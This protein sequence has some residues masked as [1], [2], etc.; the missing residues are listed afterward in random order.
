MAAP[1]L[2]PGTI[3]G[4]FRLVEELGAGGMGVVYRAHDTTLKRDVA[5]KVLNAQRLTDEKARQRFHSEALIL[6]RLSHPNVEYVH[7]FRSEEGIDFLVLEYVPGTTLNE[8]IKRGALPEQEV[9]GLGIQLARGLAAAHAQRVLHRDLKPGN[10]RLTPE[11]VLKILDFGLA[12]LM[13]LPEDDTLEMSAAQS[14]LAGTPAYL[15]PEQIEGRDPDARSDIYSAGVVLYELA[16]GSKPFPQGRQTMVEMILHSIPPAPRS[17]NKEISPE[18]DAIILKCLEKDPKQRYQ[19]A[20]DLLAD[21]E[22]VSFE[23]HSS[24]RA[25]A[26][27]HF[28]RKPQWQK[29]ALIAVACAL[30]LALAG[31]LAWRNWG[32]REAQQKIMAVLPMDTAGQDPATSAL[33]LGLTETVTAKLVQASDSS[34][35]QVVSPQDLRDQKVQSAEDARREFGT[36]YVL[37]S[38]LQRSGNTIRVNCYLVDSKTHRQ[39]AAKTIESDTTDPFGLQDKVVIAALDMLPTKLKPEE[40]RKLQVAQTVPPAAYE[41]YIRG[42]GYLQEYEKPENIEN[43]IAEFRKAIGIDA[44]Y[45]TAYAGLGSAY[46]MEFSRLDKGNEVATQASQ[47]CQ[48][49]LSLNPDLLEAHICMGTILNGTGKY[50]EAVTEFRKA[51][52]SNSQNDQA[53]RGLAEAYE[54]AGNLSGAESTYK[55][56]LTLHPNYWGA[57]HSLGLF[58][59]RQSRYADA[60]SMFQKEVQIAPDNYQSYTTLGGVAITLGDYRKAI[61]ASQRSID[62]R[63]NPDAYSNLAYTYYLMRRF[64]D[65][66]NAQ[67]QA[68]K[69]DTGNW[70]VWGNLGD[71]LYWS[72]DRKSE[73]ED[74][75]KHAVELATSRV[76][77]NPR[78]ARTMV[79]LGSYL[80]MLGRQQEALQYVERAVGET[81]SDSEVAFRAAIVY[82]H[83][84]QTD[85][86]LSYLKK[87]VKLGYSKPVIRDSP[88][89]QTLQGNSQFKMLVG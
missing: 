56:A 58:Y 39:V 59:Y 22:L 34:A 47:S 61:E 55:E 24:G 63:P 50:P 32:S 52:D 73:A 85:Q 4:H 54:N 1:T 80:G 12:E 14:P 25:L 36:D 28:R 23:S 46:W 26:M 70:E 16:T 76:Q 81:P 11:N 77:L 89:F 31:V 21:L 40:L 8:L 9:I 48:K 37:E 18:L 20:R 27:G 71:V 43:A 30:V 49:A 13:V 42:R 65:S 64:P 7:E 87:A 66:I 88:E 5:I 72:S 19:S 45:A 29:P 41:A 15:S 79:Y 67:E 82:N 83:F 44:N 35:V 53:L 57:Y 33:G 84:G 69:L 38:N 62:I 6:S 86:T 60:A 68:L 10:L 74:K 75:Y 3:L 2:N 17:K 78:D 51:L